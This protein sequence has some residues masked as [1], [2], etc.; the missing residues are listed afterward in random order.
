MYT[1]C[2]E[3][4]T[5]ASNIK[6][7]SFVTRNMAKDVKSSSTKRE[8]QEWTI[9]KPKLEEARWLRDIYFIDPD[10]AEFKKNMMNAQEKIGQDHEESAQG[11][12]RQTSHSQI[13][14]MYTLWRPTNLQQSVA[15]GLKL[16]IM[17]IPLQVWDSI[18]A[19]LTNEN[20]GSERRGGQRMGKGQ[21]K[22]AWQLTK[23]RS[24]KR[25]HSGGRERKRNSPFFY[26]DC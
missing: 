20:T 16:E 8:K 3:R 18:Q 22:P 23:V 14:N 12:W 4:L 19:P 1:C 15:K 26:I 24:K 6:A 5:K 2:R 11:N 7:R 25:G 9:E 10:D 13:K 17:K 21:K